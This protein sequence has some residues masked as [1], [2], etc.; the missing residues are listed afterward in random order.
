ML[1][2]TLLTCLNLASKQDQ[3]IVIGSS[4]TAWS[5]LFTVNP[6]TSSSNQTWTSQTSDL[7]SS[8]Q[9][10]F[11]SM[12]QNCFDF[13]GHLPEGSLASCGTV[14]SFVGKAS[15]LLHSL[16]MG[17]ACHFEYHNCNITLN[18]SSKMVHGF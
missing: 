18:F 9:A 16:H 3:Q 7:G 8:F 2:K 1:P 10:H 12:Q 6:S 17:L 11:A 4:N 13:V 15:L 5:Q 14:T